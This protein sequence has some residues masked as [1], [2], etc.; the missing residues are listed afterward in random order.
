MKLA[1][2][3][4]VTGPR[5]DL[6]V[7]DAY[8]V[9]DGAIRNRAAVVVNDFIESTLGIL[10]NS[11]GIEDII[12]LADGLMN[13][14][15]S[16]E[17]IQQRLDA[18]LGFSKSDF[19]ALADNVKSDILSRMGVEADNTGGVQSRVYG[20]NVN[21]SPEKAE[22]V[23][24]ITDVLK[25]LSDDESR[26]ALIDL[27]AET[28]LY[29][30]IL[31]ESVDAGVDTGIEVV[32]EKA[33]DPIVVKKA[34]LEGIGSAINTG[35]VSAIE[36]LKEE[37]GSKEILS[38]YPDICLRILQTYRFPMGR[39]TDYDSEYSRI[40]TLLTD[41][42]PTWDQVTRNSEDITKLHPFSR[43]S[44]D[45]WRL[46]TTA[47]DAA[48]RPLMAEMLVAKVYLRNSHEELLREQY[49]YAPL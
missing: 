17:E 6:A 48:D 23:R 12:A 18:L 41:L 25:G 42:D 20:N 8:E 7:V 49:P 39:L 32:K 13:G 2:S 26:V 3:R 15:I 29:S 38:R 16:P 46:F 11:P 27:A 44:Y 47:S 24:L 36:K 19:E 9:T 35:N 37:V 1:Q 14:G 30:G 40:T 4:F 21:I 43:A 34:A 22:Q 28:A 10:R 31:K 5:D 45:A 33:S